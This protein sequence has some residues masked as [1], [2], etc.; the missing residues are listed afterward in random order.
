MDSVI[1]KIR[2]LLLL[3]VVPSLGVLFFLRSDWTLPTNEETAASNSGEE[4]VEATRDPFPGFCRETLEVRVDDVEF[5]VC[6]G[7]AGREEPEPAPHHCIVDA[8]EAPRAELTLYSVPTLTTPASVAETAYVMFWEEFI[9]NMGLS[10]LQAVREIITEWYQSNLE[11]I[12]AQQEGGITIHELAQC[13]RSV[14]DLQ[15]RLAPYLTASQLI[16]IVANFDAFSEYVDM[17][18]AQRNAG[19]LSRS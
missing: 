18:N 3:S 10:D 16:D 7:R 12:F 13:I 1:S 9:G 8:A 2:G 14:E 15:A 4:L 5:K 11:L 6:P 17:E 19:A